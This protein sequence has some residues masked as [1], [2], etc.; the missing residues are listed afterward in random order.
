MSIGLNGDDD[1]E[2]GTRVDV[3]KLG[4]VDQHTSKLQVGT[5]FVHR[6]LASSKRSLESCQRAPAKCDARPMV[7]L[8]AR[9][10]CFMVVQRVEHS[11]HC[12]S[13]QQRQIT[14]DDDGLL[15][16]CRHLV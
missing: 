7:S 13:G 11:S 4:F 10:R 12:R 9:D 14:C 1:V 2:L 3:R 15:Q 5:C 8:A 6:L 16:R